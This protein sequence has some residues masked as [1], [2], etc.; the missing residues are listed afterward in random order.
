MLD[1]K[2]ARPSAAAPG[3]VEGTV[4]ADG[5]SPISKTDYSRKMIRGEAGVIAKL[6]T[7]GQSNA[8]PLKH[9]VTLTG[10]PEREIRRQ[11]E[12]ERRQGI[13]ILADCV[14][15]YFLPADEAELDRCVKSMRG[16]AHEILKTASAIERSI[17]EDG[18]MPLPG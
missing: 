14:G 4:Q 12:S 3:R 1:K 5:A 2:E 8:I 15:G 9:L 6:L 7:Y 11:I 13:P 17:K 10:L 18:S 16:R